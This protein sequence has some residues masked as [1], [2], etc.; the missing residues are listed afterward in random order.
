MRKKYLLTGSIGIFFICIIS[1]LFVIKPPGTVKNILGVKHNGTLSFISTDKAAINEPFD[2]TVMMDT[3]GRNVNATGIYL[4]FDPQKLQLLQLDT[5]PSFC[6]FYP[7]KKYDNQLG[8]VSL[9]CGSPHPGINGTGTL[10]IM[11]FIPLEIGDTFIRTSEKSQILQSDGKG[12]NILT[13]YP[14]AKITVVNRL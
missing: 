8:T 14:A 2:I 1:L 6:Q 13:N 9:A 12:T 4:K 10:M 11:Q 5:K 3:S 7:E